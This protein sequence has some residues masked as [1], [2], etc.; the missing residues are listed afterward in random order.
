[1]KIASIAL[2]I[3]LTG[4]YYVGPNP[5]GPNAAFVKQPPQTIVTPAAERPVARPTQPESPSEWEQKA[6]QTAAVAA[7]WMWL[8]S[9]QAYQ[10]AKENAKQ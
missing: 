2:M 10:W 8:K 1:M 6:K 3:S 4:C 9:K 5:N 7:E